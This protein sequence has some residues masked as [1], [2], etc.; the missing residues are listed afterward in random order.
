MFATL[1]PLSTMGRS[2]WRDSIEDYKP[3]RIDPSGENLKLK[4]FIWIS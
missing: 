2:L 1:G 4:D 3:A